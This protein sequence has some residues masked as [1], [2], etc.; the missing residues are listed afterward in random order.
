LA[1]CCP[2]MAYLCDVF[3]TSHDVRREAP[4]LQSILLVW[5]IEG[6]SEQLLHKPR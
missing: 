2:G 1:K 5:V 3:A 6:Y 4:Y